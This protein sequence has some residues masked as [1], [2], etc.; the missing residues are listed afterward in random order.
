VVLIIASSY[1]QLNGLPGKIL[2]VENYQQA[3]QIMYLRKGVDATVL[4]EPPFPYFLRQL[5]LKPSDFGKVLFI[6][7]RDQWIFVRR[8]LPP[9]KKIILKKVTEQLDREG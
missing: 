3:L 2:R 6:D 8:N 7:N 4:S 5:K 1:P 9:E